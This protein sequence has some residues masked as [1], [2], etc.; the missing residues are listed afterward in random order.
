MRSLSQTAA[1]DGVLPQERHALDSTITV[2]YSLA[3]L[4][5]DVDVEDVEE[6]VEGGAEAEDWIV[7]Y[8]RSELEPCS[9]S[10]NKREEKSSDAIKGR[11]VA[12]L[13]A[14]VAGL[15]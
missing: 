9:P 15:K 2:T 5:D 13:Q 14:N 8:R 3:E 12:V 11:L 6:G 10:E 1:S 4:L 7:S